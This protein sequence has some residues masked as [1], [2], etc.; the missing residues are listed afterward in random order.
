LLPRALQ[1]VTKHAA[2]TSVAIT[3]REQEGG[4]LFEVVDDGAGF[5]EPHRPRGAGL[6]NMNATVSARWAGGCP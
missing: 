1:N 6:T 2:A 5:D 3:V 4:L